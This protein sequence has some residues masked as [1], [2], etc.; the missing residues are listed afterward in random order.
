[1]RNAIIFGFLTI[2]AFGLAHTGRIPSPFEISA[3]F[4]AIVIGGYHWSLEG[5]EELIEEKKIGIEILMMATTFGSALLGIWDEAAFPVF[6]YG[7]AEGL[8][9]YAYARTR[10]FIRNSSTC[11]KGCKNHRQWERGHSARGRS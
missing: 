3:F 6:H 5:I 8:E 7:G 10:E 11:T 4:V 9:H 2:S 1:M